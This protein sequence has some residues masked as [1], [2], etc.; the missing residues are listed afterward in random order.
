MIRVPY[1]TKKDR[2]IPPGGTDSTDKTETANVYILSM[3]ERSRCCLDNQ[4]RPTAIFIFA[5]NRCIGV[6]LDKNP[7]IRRAGRG[8]DVHRC[9]GL[10]RRVSEEDG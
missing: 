10:A 8:G 5:E 4:Q 6:S 3:L 2:S 7:G 1:T 9:V